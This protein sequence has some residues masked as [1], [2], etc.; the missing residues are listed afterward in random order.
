[1]AV[2]SQPHAPAALPLADYSAT[3]RDFP[4]RCL[5][6]LSVTGVSL[7]SL[8]DEPINAQ[9]WRFVQAVLTRCTRA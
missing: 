9:M 1:M 2:R 5:T 6:A 4:T 7:L 3:H 8:G